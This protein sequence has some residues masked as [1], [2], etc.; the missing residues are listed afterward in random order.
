MKSLSTLIGACVLLVTPVLADGPA[1]TPAAAHYEV[2]FMT[3]MIDHHHM[4]VMMSEHCL[5][6]AKTP[7]LLAM[8]EEIIKTQSAEI[9]L[10]QP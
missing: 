6:N 5:K 7:D 10:L 2:K 9:K 3:D 4:A 8:C 1:P